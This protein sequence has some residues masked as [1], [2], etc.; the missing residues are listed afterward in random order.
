MHTLSLGFSPCPN[1]TFIFDALIHSKIYTE[2]LSFSPVLDDVE[3]LNRK[4]IVGELDITKL[5]YAAFTTVS[6]TYQLLTAGSA[7]GKG[8]GPLLISLK[9]FKV[10]EREI[11]TVAIPGKHTT[12]NFLFSIFYPGLK[13][14]QEMVFSDIEEA[15]LS[16]KADAGVIIHE[17]RFTYEK[18]GLRKICDLGQKWEE[19]TGQP[20]PLGG[21]A[22]RKA[23]SEEIKLK[24]NRAIRR[25]VEFAF[26]NP[27]S[28]SE[29]VQM[30]AQEMDEAVRK[31]HINLYVNN[32][33]IDIG[34]EGREAIETMFRMA[35]EAGS[36]CNVP[37]RIFVQ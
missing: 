4:A 26:S 12:A 30:H 28:S 34:P 14:T 36:I 31:M 35:Q 17:N 23:L 15:V 1:D 11:K 32:Y 33:S 25:S 20:I 5:S 3:T 19:K 22:I 29:Y 27:E 8:V 21:I 9:D 18:K 10:P 13:N 6:E 16:G 24:V 37:E 7:L 2:G